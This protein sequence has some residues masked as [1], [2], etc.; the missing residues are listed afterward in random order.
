MQLV[1]DKSLKD[2][3]LDYIKEKRSVSFAELQKR[4]PGL[5]GNKTFSP[6]G[7]QLM[8]L[9]A[10][11]SE[12]GCS[13]MNE[14]LMSGKVRLVPCSEMLYVLDGIVPKLP[15]AKKACVFKKAH[16]LPVELHYIG[17]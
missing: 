15:I 13:A 12:Q 14:V 9:W 10:S 4:I 16:W 3:I 1:E 7:N 8:L 5:E 2:L 6:V 11:F 17:G